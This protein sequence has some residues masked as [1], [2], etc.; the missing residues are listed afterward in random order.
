[1]LESH[2]P[3]SKRRQ[4][5]PLRIIESN[6]DMKEVVTGNR[7]VQIPDLHLK[8]VTKHGKSN[9][10]AANSSLFASKNQM[11]SNNV[12]EGVSTD[13]AKQPYNAVAEPDSGDYHSL[14]NIGMRKQS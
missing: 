14:S 1:M 7:K 3:R 4:G 10:Q 11:I 6:A 13:R 12:A 9:S 5:T 2:V 8:A